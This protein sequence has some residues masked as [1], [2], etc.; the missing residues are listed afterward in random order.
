MQT[1]L[2]ELAGP[3]FDPD[4]TVDNS[5]YL[6]YDLLFELPLPYRVTTA[7]QRRLY[8]GDTPLVFDDDEHAFY[9][10]P[11]YVPEL[12]EPEG[13][14]GGGSGPSIPPVPIVPGAGSWWDGFALRPPAEQRA[15]AAAETAV[16]ATRLAIE[17]GPAP[18]GGQLPGLDTVNAFVGSTSDTQ[19]TDVAVRSLAYANQVLE[20]SLSLEVA[21]AA[22]APPADGITVYQRRWRIDPFHHPYTCH[23]LALLNRSGVAA[24]F[25]G[26]GR[27][28]AS[29][30]V[31]THEPGAPANRPYRPS[32]FVVGP[33]PSTT[34]TS[35]SAGRTAST[36]GSCSS[37]RRCYIA[38]RLRREGRFDEAQRWYHFIF[39]PT[40]GSDGGSGPARFWNIKP[41]YKDALEGP[42]DVIRT[43]FSDDG[44]QTDPDIAKSFFDSIGQWLQNP[45][46]PHAI[47]RVR[48]GTYQKVVVRKYLD[49]LIDWGDSL[50]RRDTIESINEATQIYLLAAAILGE[51]PR[52]LAELT[53][54]VRTYDDL[55][56]PI[57][58][59]GLTQLEGF[60][61]ADAAGWCGRPVRG[62]RTAGAAGLV[63][64]LPAAERAAAAVLG[65]GRATGCSRSGT[66]R[67]STGSSGSCA[68]RA[69]DRP[70]AAG[71][72]GRRRRRHRRGA[73]RPARTAAALPVR[74]AGREGDR[75]AP[76]VQALGAALLSVAGEARRRAARA[77]ALGARD[78][79]AEG[80]S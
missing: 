32:S 66:A 55:S 39:D 75:P 15:L 3:V 17:A 9:V 63:V 21:G 57:L 29:E 27:Q 48:I 35:R 49:Q 40:R 4:D 42:V 77:A 46:S 52:Q 6:A 2:P 20:A 7:R 56:F 33:T 79:A 65:H 12:L 58:F 59:G 67:T 73:R 47:A 50:F 62:G 14:T 31:V 76:E 78:R 69:A 16:P 37:T 23:L 24:L 70:G 71:P 53:T 60:Y 28:L 13:T 41:L 80:G 72:R 54:P 18:W 8:L 25:T 10:V 61:P 36:T 64:L 74:H 5:G 44:L 34:T 43:I 45:F 51:R 22:E 11:V 38:E 19:G 68:V 1:Y 26:T 30:A